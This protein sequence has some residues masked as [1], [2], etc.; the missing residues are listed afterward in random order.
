MNM[1]KVYDERSE[2]MKT[3]KLACYELEQISAR[4][5]YGTRYTVETTYFDYGQNWKYSAII[6]NKDNG[7]S[8]QALCPRD[9]ERVLTADDIKATCEDIANG[10]YFYDC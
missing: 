9:Y 7:N 4:N 6:A 8:W 5:G 1:I 10:T 3:L 2:E